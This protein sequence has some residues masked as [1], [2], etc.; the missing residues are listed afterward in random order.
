M[1]L[2]GHCR[3]PQFCLVRKSDFGVAA[4]HPPVM[5]RMPFC[6]KKWLLWACS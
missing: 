2:S 1:N 3:R 4:W 5:R 6:L